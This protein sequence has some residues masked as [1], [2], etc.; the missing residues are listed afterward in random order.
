MSANWIQ[1]P[2]RKHITKGEIMFGVLSVESSG[3]S[4]GPKEQAVLEQELLGFEIPV[5]GIAHCAHRKSKCQG[6]LLKL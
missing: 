2:C 6:I 5:K 4:L 3:S 1:P